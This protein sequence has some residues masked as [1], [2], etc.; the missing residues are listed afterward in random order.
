MLNEM[1]RIVFKLSMNVMITYI[2]QIFVFL[3]KYYIVVGAVTGWARGAKSLQ[4][5]PVPVC[6]EFTV[7]RGRCVYQ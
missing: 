6:H 3:C 2:V 5:T 1:L 7:G 4:A